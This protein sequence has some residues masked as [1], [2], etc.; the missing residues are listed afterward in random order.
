MIIICNGA[1][2]S[3][4]TWLYLIVEELLKLKKIPFN[5]KTNE[6]WISEKNKSFLFNDSNIVN[7]I[8]HYQKGN[9]VYLSKVHLLEKN[10]YKFLK[11]R[12]NG[13]NVK[14][15]FTSRNLGDALVSHYHHV[16][17]QT[18]K[19]MSFNK[20]YKLI[21]RYKA[22]EIIKFNKNRVNYLPGTLQIKFEDLKS[23]FNVQV[24]N[25]ANELG[26]QISDAD[27]NLIKEKT[28]ID[29]LKDKV[30]KG[31]IS[32][33]SKNS[34]K[35]S[36]LFRKGEVGE[37]RKFFQDKQKDDLNKI[38]KGEMGFFFKL[39]YFIFFVLRRNFYKI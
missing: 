35:A 9:E 37:S 16:V 38:A 31:E 22:Y 15:L 5:E 34:E 29:N 20:Y 8:N 10:S 21:G 27:I 4:S 14:V 23:N 17:T 3:G 1:F 2:K 25:I 36:K 7:A 32:Q 39:Y 6:T 11:D 33:Y 26:L 19:K 28:S 30:K 24:N 13:R 18:E 12:V